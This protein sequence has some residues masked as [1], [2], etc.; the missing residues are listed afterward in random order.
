KKNPQV[1]FDVRIGK[2]P[3]W[4]GI[5]ILL[6]ADIVPKTAETFDAYAL[7]KRALAIKGSR[8]HRVIPGFMI[9]GGDFTNNNGTGGKIHL[10]EKVC[11]RK[12]QTKALG[13][14]NIEH[15]KLRPR[16]KTDLNSLSRVIK[17][18][19]WTTSMSYSEK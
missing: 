12:L 11:R 15:G 7:K 3:M 16:Y 2:G 6:R 4:V 18:T 9:Q 14:W 17:Q 10:W 8:F 19:G 1:Y 13:R 5:I